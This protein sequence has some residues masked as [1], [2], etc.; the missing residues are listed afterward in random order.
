MVRDLNAAGPAFE[1]RPELLADVEAEAVRGHCRGGKGNY[2]AG[3][4]LAQNLVAGGAHGRQGIGRRLVQW[5]EET[6]TVAGLFRVRLEVRAIK[7][8]ARSFY[9]SLGYRETDRI[10]RYYSGVEDAIKLSRDL[11]AVSRPPPSLRKR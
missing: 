6:A 11:R 7:R 8:D 4:D 10:E 3:R 2:L 9:A 1:R 5:V